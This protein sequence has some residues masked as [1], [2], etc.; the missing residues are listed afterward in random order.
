ME[1]LFDKEIGRRIGM[2]SDIRGK[3]DQCDLEF[4]RMMMNQ[5][6]EE[7][8]I[9]MSLEKMKVEQESKAQIEGKQRELDTLVAKH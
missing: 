2:S 6:N 5:R 3:V 9:S 8:R 7:V 1:A 4:E